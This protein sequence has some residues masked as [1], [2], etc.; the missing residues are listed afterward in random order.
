MPIKCRESESCYNDGCRSEACRLAASDAR[1]ERRRLSREAV[2]GLDAD[3]T[4]RTRVVSVVP[5]VT[6]SE[7]GAES[8]TCV[9]AVSREIED[10]GGHS[11]PGLA[12]AAMALAAVLDNPRATSSKPS[13]AGALVNILNQLRKSAAGAKPKLA[14]V[15]QMAYQ[16]PRG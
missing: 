4:N 11:R 5:G 15:R 7:S 2:G 14:S 13:A 10:L 1:R 8:L 6:H 9:D 3:R 12:A 16:K